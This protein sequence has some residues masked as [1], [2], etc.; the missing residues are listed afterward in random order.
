MHSRVGNESD[1]NSG[2][3]YL[4]EISSGLVVSGPCQDIPSKVKDTLVYLDSPTT[5]KEA[6]Y[7]EGLFGFEKQHFL[8]LGVLL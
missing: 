5:E 8:H 4:S 1:E 6:Q 3:F 7:L 2:A